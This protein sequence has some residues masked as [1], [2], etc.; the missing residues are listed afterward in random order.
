MSVAVSGKCGDAIFLFEELFFFFPSVTQNSVQSIQRDL[1]H[2]V[3]LVIAEGNEGS[4]VSLSFPSQTLYTAI[5][6]PKPAQNV[7]VSLSA[8]D[9]FA[10]SWLR[11]EAA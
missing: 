9:L 7:P 4:V 2:F 3:G 6:S 8:C 11:L 10:K 1:F 5:L